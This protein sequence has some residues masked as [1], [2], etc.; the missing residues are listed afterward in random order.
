MVC[1]ES[2]AVEMHLNI[3]NLFKHL[4]VYCLDLRK[5]IAQIICTIK[6]LLFLEDG[7]DLDLTSI[8]EVQEGVPDSFA[9]QQ[10]ELP[11][12]NSLNS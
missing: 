7:L 6:Y 8:S 3:Y 2:W 10:I 12:T 1:I 4:N 11:S 9:S 5:K